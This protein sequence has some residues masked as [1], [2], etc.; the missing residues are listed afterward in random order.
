MQ[1]RAF[2]I[3]CLLSALSLR[4]VAVAAQ[5]AFVPGV[6]LDVLHE[7]NYFTVGPYTYS[8]LVVDRNGALYGTSPFGGPFDAGSVFRLSPPSW[9]LQILHAFQGGGD[10]AQPYGGV[11][12]D[13]SGAAYVGACNGGPFNSGMVVKLS[14]PTTGASS[15][16]WVETVLHTFTGGADGA[17]P[18]STLISDVSG[19]LYG[20]A[21]SGGTYNAGLVFKLSPA[22]SGVTSWS[23]SVLYTFTGG[24]DGR[25]PLAGL[26][27]Q[28]GVLY[29]MTEFGGSN[30]LGTAFALSPSSSADSP[31]TE[32]VIYTFGA[33]LDGFWPSNALVADSRGWLYGV[34]MGGPA[35]FGIAFRL[36]PVTMTGTWRFT[37]LH[38][39]TAGAD[40]GSPSGL[41]WDGNGGLVGTAAIGGSGFADAGNGLVFE[42]SP[43]KPWAERV[44]HVFRNNGDGADP[45]SGLVADSSGAL[46]GSTAR[47]DANGT[48]GG[49]VF[50]LRYTIRNFWPRSRR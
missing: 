40:G 49:R 37:R 32:S 33:G 47:S 38:A 23:E 22:S 2:W 18:C 42:L 6:Q 9:T 3:I 26:L 20:T 45:I 15:T 11:L 29:G 1:T 41:V 43:G 13:S 39:F 46:Y 16:P 10:G 8:P 48:N 30:R 7:L 12:L 35:S 50:R 28:R 31:W 25:T 5:N 4:P 24:P 44:L 21:Y 14:P 17:G 36:A 34:A 27:A 19:S